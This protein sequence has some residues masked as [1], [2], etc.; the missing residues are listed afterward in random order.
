[1][2]D[3]YITVDA[4]GH[5]GYSAIRVCN[6]GAYEAVIYVNYGANWTH[7]TNGSGSFTKD[8]TVDMKTCEPMLKANDP[9]R[10]RLHAKAGNH[11]NGDPI[12]Y[13]PAGPIAYY[14]CNGTV[15]TAKMHGPYL[16]YTNDGTPDRDK[17]YGK[18]GG[19]KG[20]WPPWLP[21]ND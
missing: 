5:T 17:Q 3:S 18:T 9:M 7:T 12:A 15:Q 16:S 8:V 4:D 19:P 6:S 11:V 20:G 21:I 13:D 10:P 2:A 1:M 14:Y